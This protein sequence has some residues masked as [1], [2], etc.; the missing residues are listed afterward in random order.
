MKAYSKGMVDGIFDNQYG[1]GI[2]KFSEGEIS[3]VPFLLKL[4]SFRFH[5]EV[6]K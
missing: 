2:T 3:P 1:K 4:K 6:S 5:E